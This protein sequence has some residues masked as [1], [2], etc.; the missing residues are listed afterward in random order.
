MLQSVDIAGTV[1]EVVD[2]GDFQSSL[3]KPLSLLALELLEILLVY[4]LL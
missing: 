4:V 1:V 3:Q 2:D